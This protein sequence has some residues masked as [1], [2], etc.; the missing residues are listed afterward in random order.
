MAVTVNLSSAATDEVQ[1]RT[2]ARERSSRISTDLERYYEALR[3]ARA[4]LQQL[5]TGAEMA[6]IVDASN[7]VLYEPYSVALLEHG[8]NDAIRLDGLATK[9]KV[10]GP[11]LIGKLADLTYIEKAAII[12]AVEIYWKRVGAPES[13]TCDPNLALSL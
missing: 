5:L 13:E 11:A 2:N 1:K 9:W 7:G 6:L 12:D 10:D 3:R 4:R 8:V